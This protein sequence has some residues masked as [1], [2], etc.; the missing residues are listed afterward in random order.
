[1]SWKLRVNR[2]GAKGHILW[3]LKVHVLEAWPPVYQCWD[4][5]SNLT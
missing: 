5:R 4:I 1:M 3:V 2:L